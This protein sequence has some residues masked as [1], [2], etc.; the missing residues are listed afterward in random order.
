MILKPTIHVSLVGNPNCGKSALFNLLTGG[1][2]HVGCF[3]GVTVEKKEG[4]VKNTDMT[5]T[6]LPGIYSLTAYSAEEAVTRDYL[7]TEHPDVI[8]NVID[9]TAPIKGLYLTFSLLTLGIP[10]VIVFN[11]IDEADRYGFVFDFNGLSKDLNTRAL[12]LSA[13]SGRGSAE[14]IKA[15]K[16]IFEIYNNSDIDTDYQLIGK[17]S[18]AVMSCGGK[19]SH[20]ISQVKEIVSKKAKSARLPA[21]YAAQAVF[22][23]DESIIA[24]LSLSTEESVRI[25]DVKSAISGTYTENAFN[26]TASILAAERYAAAEKLA[27]RYIKMPDMPLLRKGDIAADRILTSKLLAVPL[28]AAI[29]LSVFY[30]SF[31]FSGGIPGAMI[32]RAFTAAGEAIS[33]LIS[34]MGASELVCS[35]F[36]DGIVRGTGSVISFLPVILTLFFF[37]SV[38]EDS[39]YM[40]RIAFITDAPLRKLGLSGRSV[41]PLLIGFG[42]TVPA[43]MAS[44]TLPDR[45]SREMTAFLLPYMSCA[46]KMPVYAMFALAFFG[47]FAPLYMLLIYI[48]G[49][50][51]GII[52]ASMMKSTIFKKG[53]AGFLL[54]M[55]PYRLPSART[56]FRDML[57]RAWEFLKK[58]FTIVLFTSVIIWAARTYGFDLHPVDDISDSILAHIGKAFAYILR[59][60]GLGD[61]RAASAL[62]AGLGAKENIISTLGVLLGANGGEQ[63]YTALRS[64]FSPASA[65]SFICFVLLYSPCAAALYSYR[66]ELSGKKAVAAMAAQTCVAYIAA[67]AV[68]FFANLFTF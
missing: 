37:L 50:C 67:T 8:I 58:A 6:D 11:M 22:E 3:P 31:S 20:A 59:P 15:T 54:E 29:M 57:K 51:F 23:G 18:A 27:R 66:K 21:A 62:L 7:L 42:C 47:S 38:L 19:I 1:N 24:M 55:P 60:T 32:E 39:G 5:V 9:A 63:F 14:L 43:I 49:I 40:A 36:T 68:F 28:F 2:Q 45:R 33:G 44:R 48:T 13:T 17:K 26:R 4:R 61:W 52:A 65:Y 30:I 35:L 25:N 41:V 56:V 46:A 64:I 34:K 16:S 53:D 12:P 10:M